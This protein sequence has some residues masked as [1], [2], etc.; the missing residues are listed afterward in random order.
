[1][2]THAAP[3]P[4]LE[5]WKAIAR[6]LG[7]DARTALRWVDLGLPVCR[8]NGRNSS[9]Y[10]YADDLEEWLRRRSA[11]GA[12]ILGPAGVASL[13][14]LPSASDPRLP[15]RAR[16]ATDV[17]ALDV[18]GLVQALARWLAQATPDEQRHARR[19]FREALARCVRRAAGSRSAAAL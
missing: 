4:R 12:D 13:R 14:V 16:L 11:E 18:E 2:G 3:G 7:K 15:G 19:A 10:A 1:M 17:H 5:G 6:Y 9:V 8:V